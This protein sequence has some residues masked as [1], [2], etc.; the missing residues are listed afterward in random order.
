M[1]PL[2]WDL[3]CAVPQ[4]PG[5]GL[6]VWPLALPPAIMAGFKVCV[7]QRQQ[8]GSL[9]SLWPN[10]CHAGSL[11]CHHT[12]DQMQ[13]GL[14]SH[15]EKGVLGWGRSRSSPSERPV[16]GSARDESHSFIPFFSPWF[17]PPTVCGFLPAGPWP[18]LLA[19]T[20]Q[21]WRACPL[22]HGHSHPAGVSSSSVFSPKGGSSTHCC[23]PRPI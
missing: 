20:P 8:G 19:S 6:L 21:L 12:Y 23:E 13:G 16:D 4:M 10:G 1:W 11:C 5:H 7:P 18:V 14:K 3:R 9:M 2:G 17:R 22:L 15:R